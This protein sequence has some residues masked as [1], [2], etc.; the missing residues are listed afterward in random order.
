MHPD[1]L[2]VATGDKF[3]FIQ[4]WDIPNESKVI[5]LEGHDNE[6]NAISFSENG[7]NMVS[8]SKKDNIIKLWDLR[9]TN[10]FI[11]LKIDE[12]SRISNLKFDPSGRYLAVAEENLRIIDCKKI[13][14]H[15][16]ISNDLNKQVNDVVFDPNSKFLATVS[17]DNYLRIFSKSKQN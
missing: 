1:S 17:D 8:S 9:K 7:Y 13:N 16:V 5:D 12:N 3:G 4:L 15:V 11:N 14:E 6:I 10:K 2:L